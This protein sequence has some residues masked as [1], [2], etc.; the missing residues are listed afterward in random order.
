[1]SRGS[2]LFRRMPGMGAGPRVLLSIAAVL[3]P[4]AVVFGWLSAATPREWLP[5]AWVEVALW[6]AFAVGGAISWPTP[7]DLRPR[8]V[9][10]AWP[11]LCLL[12]ALLA[13][14]MA[15]LF[16]RG[17]GLDGDAL[18][19]AGYLC[20]VPL[21]AGGTLGSLALLWARAAA[22]SRTAAA[23]SFGLNALAVL[24]LFGGA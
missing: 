2:S 17:F 10:L 18:V 14:G 19:Y 8:F 7:A 24:L 22:V 23:S 12:P 4:F 15:S 5:P 21:V 11:A 3:P 20:V 6:E 13:L 1:M 9:R 16:A